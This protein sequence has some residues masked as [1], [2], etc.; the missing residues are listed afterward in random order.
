MSVGDPPFGEPQLRDLERN[1]YLEPGPFTRSA[2]HLEAAIHE[3]C[4]WLELQGV[5]QTQGMNK[6]GTQELDGLKVTMVHALHSSSLEED[7]QLLYMGEA[8]GFVVE[9]ENGKRIYHAGDTA[10]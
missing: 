2:F 7:G 4:R 3:L 5:E 9:L 1:R 6:G 10:V 8:A